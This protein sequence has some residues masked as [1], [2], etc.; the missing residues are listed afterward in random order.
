M[1]P[2]KRES[3]Q[4][5]VGPVILNMAAGYAVRRDSEEPLP[6]VDQDSLEERM[7][8]NK[9]TESESARSSILTTILKTLNDK[10][11]ETYEHS[12]R[13]AEM[14]VA[15]VNGMNLGPEKKDEIIL[16]SNLHDIGKIAIPENILSKPGKLS[17]VDGAISEAA[18]DDQCLVG[19]GEVTQGLRSFDEV[20]LHEGHSGRAGEKFIK[21]FDAS[22]LGCNANE[23]V[24]ISWDIL[25][26]NWLF[27]TFAASSLLLSGNQFFRPF[28]FCNVT[29]YANNFDFAI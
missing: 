17:I 15:I 1:T 13:I 10:S 25:A 19:L 18:L 7:Y 26:K 2:S 29:A 28:S 6:C 27:D 3:S 23:R 22:F 9:I 16:L 11:I 20:T 14:G 5:Q 12:R 4:E 8:R 21:T 24:L